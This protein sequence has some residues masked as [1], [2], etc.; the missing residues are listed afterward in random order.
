ML[1]QPLVGLHGN[2]GARTATDV[3]RN[4][5]RLTVFQGGDDSFA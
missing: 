4:P 3:Y 1:L 2:T 5:I